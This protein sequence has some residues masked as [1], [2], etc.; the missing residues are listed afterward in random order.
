MGNDWDDFKSGYNSGSGIGGCLGAIV[1]SLFSGAFSILTA[2]F[3]GILNMN[4]TPVEDKLRYKK[5]LP[6]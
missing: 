1:L 6:T 5:N 4:Q 2:M 3:V